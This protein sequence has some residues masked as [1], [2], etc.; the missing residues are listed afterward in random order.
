M[1]T[2]EAT[3]ELLPCPFCG[4]REVDVITTSAQGIRY[5]ARCSGCLCQTMTYAELESIVIRWN[6]R[7]QDEIR[8]L[9][10]ENI[11]RILTRESCVGLIN[12]RLEWHVRCVEVF[13]TDAEAYFEEHAHL[14][15]DIWV[16]VLNDL[17][18]PI[19]RGTLMPSV[20]EIRGDAT[21]ADNLCLERHS[22]LEKNRVL[23][24]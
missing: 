19:P 16:S 12:S 10:H 4:S 23:D 13:G 18:I 8:I 9:N 21:A 14:E 17:Q 6:R 2:N 20:I 24:L 7:P 22:K 15:P 11:N 3:A 1:T 5:K